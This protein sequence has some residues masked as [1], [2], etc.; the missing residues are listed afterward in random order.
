MAV[1]QTN[2]KAST[3]PHLHIAGEQCP[4]CEQPIPNERYEEISKR[5][6]VKERERQAAADARAKTEI[7]AIKSQTQA[8][9]DA[10]K[11][12]S[13]AKEAVALQQGRKAAEDVLGARLAEAAEATT[14]ATERGAAL[15]AQLEAAKA[16]TAAKEAA[17]VEHGKK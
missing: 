10:V 17:G 7:D 16:E 12:E 14:A 11:A 9:I 4:L 5:I 15:Q 13:A 2:V 6:V 3:K 1:L 8:Q